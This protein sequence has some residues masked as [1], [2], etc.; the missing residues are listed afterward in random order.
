MHLAA[1]RGA[2]TTIMLPPNPD[3][4]WAGRTGPSPWYTA[5]EL[6]RA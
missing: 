2:M 6:G 4:L 1:C 5:L 3:W